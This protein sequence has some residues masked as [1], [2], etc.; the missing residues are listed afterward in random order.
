[1]GWRP[2][3]GRCVVTAPDRAAYV[4]GLRELADYLEAT[5]DLPVPSSTG[6]SVHP[7]GG[8]VQARAE[9]DRVAAILGAVPETRANGDHYTVTRRFGPVTYQAI[10]ITADSQARYR[11]HMKGWRS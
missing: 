2:S 6:A 9:V 10:A 5:P 8:D 1:M 3:P 11:E 4:A 7:D